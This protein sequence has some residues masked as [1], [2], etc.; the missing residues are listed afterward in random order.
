MPTHVLAVAVGP[1]QE[2]IAAARR[3]RD[4]WFG[5]FLLSEVSKATA[6]AVRHAGGELI[7]PNP[8]APADLDPGSPLN[9]ANVILAT[10]DDPAAV[11]DA[12][13]AA[14][15]RWKDFAADARREASGVIRNE[16]WDDQIDDVVEFYAAWVP[17]GG[18][19]PAARR[20]VMRLLAGRK[21]GRDFLPGAGRPGVP[22]SSL[23]GL[24]ESVLKDP[25]VERWPGRFRARLRVRAGEQ[26][27]VVGL[28]KRVAGGN[29]KYPSVSRVAADPWL[30]G[31]AGRLGEVIEECRRL[32]SRSGPQVVRELDTTAAGHAHFDDFPF[33]GSAVF[34]TRHHEL[35]EETGLGEADFRSL[36][37][38]VAAAGGGEPQPYLA[39][40]VA[41]GDKMGETISKLN[42]REEHQSFSA[43]LSRFAAD[44]KRIVDE[45]RGVLV[46]AGGDD[47]L[48]FVPV[49]TCLH[50]A[51]Q[52]HD[53]FGTLLA[54]LVAGLNVGR[55]SND[56]LLANMTLSVGV[57]IG[58]FLENLEDL[59][60]YGQAA[61]KHAKQPDPAGVKDALAVHLHKRGGSPIKVRAKWGDGLDRRLDEYAR[62]FNSG[63]LPSRLAYDLRRMADVYKHWPADTA[64]EAIRRDVLRLVAAKRTTANAADLQRLSAALAKRV[65]DAASLR[66]F[67]EELLVARQLA[68]AVRQATPPTDRRAP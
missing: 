3:T 62:L 68:V 67:A 53:A 39:V 46:Y 14:Q 48:A 18:D 17:L 49:H 25:A 29:P 26:L 55:V 27:D 8:T 32:N 43:E 66:A 45:H 60:Q 58:H 21:A 50:C 54:D 59:R 1:V 6:R 38:A 33:E 61:E 20:R 64:A 51:R 44:A 2:F 36:A 57:A 37:Q 35:A 23:D 47:V 15:N 24:R 28:T 9:V 41:D 12:K 56:Q 10:V 52:L 30:R 11:A 19:Y 4:L 42:S 5:S 65:T 31:R 13:L 40:L 7:F 16:I 63:A 22:K 34:R